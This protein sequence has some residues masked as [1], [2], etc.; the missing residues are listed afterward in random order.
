MLAACVVVAG[1]IGILSGGNDEQPATEEPV[2]EENVEETTTPEATTD[3]SEQSEE[4]EKEEVLT[5]D[6]SS[7]LQKLLTSDDEADFA[8]F[9]GKYAGKT[10]EFDCSIDD[11]QNH[12]NY[13]TRYDFLLSYGDYSEESQDGPSFKLEN[14][15]VSNDAFPDDSYAVGDSIHIVAEVGKFENSVFYLTPIKVTHR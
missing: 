5:I 14:Y 4:Q 15:N 9:A 11:L 8:A 1:I 12:E 10:I 6:N 7:D 13:D 3:T 2:A